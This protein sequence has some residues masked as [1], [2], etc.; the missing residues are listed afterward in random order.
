MRDFDRVL[1]LMSVGEGDEYD[2]VIALRRIGDATRGDGGMNSP[3]SQN[4]LTSDTDT[5]LPP[6]P[7]QR[8]DATP[9]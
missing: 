5:W 4:A 1:E 9:P 2:A 3:R 7:N 6:I 8:S